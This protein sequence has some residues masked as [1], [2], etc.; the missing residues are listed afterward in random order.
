M[1]A[2]RAG[3]GRPGRSRAGASVAYLAGVLAIAFIVFGWPLWPVG[4]PLIALCL[5][6]DFVIES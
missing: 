2:S 3:G 5:A 6:A 4:F 1:L